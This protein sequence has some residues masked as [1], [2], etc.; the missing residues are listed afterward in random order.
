MPYIAVA[1][2]RHA[3]FLEV[4]SALMK[5]FWDFDAEF[6]FSICMCSGERNNLLLWWT[7]RLK[8][9]VRLSRL[10]CRALQMYMCRL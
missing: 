3:R 8:V 2:Q 9:D 4:S 1:Y 6:L 7:D 10:E 5:E